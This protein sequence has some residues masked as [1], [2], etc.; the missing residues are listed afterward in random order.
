[1]EFSEKH[2]TF[3]WRIE[4]KPEGGFIA[5]SDD[6]ADTL[7]AA[8]REEIE[9]KIRERL[10][11]VMGSGLSELDLSGLDLTHP[12]THVET[13]VERKFSFSPG[14]PSP[15]TPSDAPPPAQLQYPSPGAIE[16]TGS[17]LLSAVWKAAV[18]VGIVIIIWL[19]LH[20]G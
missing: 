9:A 8:T 10:V 14:E 12:A 19:L 16:P 3:R 15:G 7:E 17:S 6:P 4:A 13:H 11:A 18:L 2:V 5:R 20:R 1:M